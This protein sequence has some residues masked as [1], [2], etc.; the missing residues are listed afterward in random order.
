MSAA[1]EA[2]L[3]SYKNRNCCLIDFEADVLAKDNQK[4]SPA[5]RQEAQAR[6]DYF[7]A[8]VGKVWREY[9]K[10]RHH[11]GWKGQYL[12]E[13]T[14][15]VRPKDGSLTV[16]DGVIFPILSA[17]SQF[18]VLSPK[19]GRWTLDV[20]AFFEDEEMIEAARE[21]LAPTTATRC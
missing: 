1:S 19:T 14:R 4:Q 12:K 18:V 16:A 13:H 17:M 3:K 2:R 8:M 7:V 15:A 11:E 10:W 6:C 21:Q 9:L 5:E 20:P